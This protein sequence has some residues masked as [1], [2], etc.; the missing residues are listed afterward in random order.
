MTRDTKLADEILTLASAT[1]LDY[2]EHVLDV[3]KAMNFTRNVVQREFERHEHFSE[4]I[5]TCGREP[6]TNK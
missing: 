6:G 5:K 2:Q 4:M 3:V 1:S